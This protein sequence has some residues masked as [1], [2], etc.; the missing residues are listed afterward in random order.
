MPTTSPNQNY[1]LSRAQ[2]D[3]LFS[4][5]ASVNFSV[6][7]HAGSP[8]CIEAYPML[9]FRLCQDCAATTFGYGTASQL[10]PEMDQVWAWFDQVI[11]ASANTNPHNW[12]DSRL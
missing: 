12:C 3:D 11:G 4:R 1:S 7:P 6:L 10:S 8:N 5:L 2:T 9:Y